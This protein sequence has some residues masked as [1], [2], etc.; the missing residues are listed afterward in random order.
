MCNQPPSTS[1]SGVAGVVLASAFLVVS[2]GVAVTLVLGDVF[3]WARGACGSAGPSTRTQKADD[4]EYETLLKESRAFFEESKARVEEAKLRAE[5]SEAVKA[6][7]EAQRA[8]AVQ[9]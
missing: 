9:N 6:F 8:K 4:E 1:L 2:S 5:A 7:L 3:A